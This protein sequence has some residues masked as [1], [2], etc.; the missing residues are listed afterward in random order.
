VWL[1]EPNGHLPPLPEALRTTSGAA[2]RDEHRA[3]AARV[4]HGQRHPY[5]KD[6]AVRLVRAG[7]TDER[8]LLVHLRAEFE[9]SCEPLP[10]P[11]AG[12]LEA[13]ARWAGRTGIAQRERCVGDAYE[14][15]KARHTRAV[16]G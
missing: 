15:F 6:F 14:V 11:R 9:L 10:T 3:P 8:R 13:L 16:G 5:L 1:L 2:G 4:P 7:V 12:A